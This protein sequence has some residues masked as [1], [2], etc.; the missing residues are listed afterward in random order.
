MNLNL[1]YEKPMVISV[2]GGQH[3][4]DFISIFEEN[5]MPVYK[6]IRSAIKALDRFVTYHLRTHRIT[7]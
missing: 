2:N 3:Y 5:G 4:L 6:D 7:P 1:K